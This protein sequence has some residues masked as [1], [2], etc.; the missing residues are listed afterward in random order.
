M[1]SISEFYGNGESLPELHPNTEINQGILIDGL[2]AKLDIAREALGKA[3]EMNVVTP[4]AVAMKDQ[5]RWALN[6]THPK[7]F[8][9]QHPN[10]G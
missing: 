8:H 1:E 7:T 3:M 2:C 6:E 5:I 9:E 4:A 10:H